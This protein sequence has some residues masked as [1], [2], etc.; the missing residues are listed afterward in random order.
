M[1]M[2]KMQSKSLQPLMI[3]SL[4]VF[5]ALV[6]LSTVQVDATSSNAWGIRNLD[7]SKRMTIDVTSN[8]VA[9]PALALYGVQGMQQYY[10]TGM[11]P[12]V[13]GAPQQQA[14][15]YQNGMYLIPSPQV[16][17]QMGG[18]ANLFRNMNR[19]AGGQTT[20]PGG[21]NFRPQGGQPHLAPSAPSYYSFGSSMGYSYHLPGRPVPN[22]YF[23]Q[24][25]QQRQQ[26]FAYGY[27]QQQGQPQQW[28]ASQSRL[29]QVQVVGQQQSQ[30]P[31]YR[32]Q[33]QGY[34]SPYMTQQTV[35]VNNVPRALPGGG[36]IFNT[37]GMTFIPGRGYVLPAATTPAGT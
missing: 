24:R 11:R 29:G 12:Q 1:T 8:A 26:Q 22:P 16:T 21:V 14:M 19:M 25:Q 7:Q 13:L 20:L 31:F 15:T 18:V 33:Q 4:V 37:G 27:G 2:S 35:R 32:P 30:T 6:L 17:Q 3:L 10:Q 36:T 5:A 23:Q 9:T 28:N 34:R